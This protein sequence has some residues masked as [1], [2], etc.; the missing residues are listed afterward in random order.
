MTGAR[1]VLA[2]GFQRQGEEVR[3]TARVVEVQSGSVVRAVKMD[4]RLSAIFE[5]QDRIVAELTTGLRGTVAAAHEGE[6]TTVVAAYEALSKGLLNLR[7]DNYESLDRA[8]VF[9]ERA[10]AIDPGYV[11]AQIELASAC[12]QKGDYLAAREYHERAVAILRGV[13]ES[14]PRL[15]RVW[16][17][18]GMTLV[19]L[20][21]VD[22][23][24][25]HLRRA[26]SLAPEDPMVLAGLARGLFVGR[27]E[28]G[29]AAALFARAVERNPQ[30][31]WYLMQLAHCY[32][33]VRD[34]ERGE[35]AARRAI[36]L[37]EAFIS[38]QQGVQLVGAYMRLGHLLSLQKRFR[39]A[40]DA[41]ASE[42]AFIERV[43]HAL[44]SRIRVE[45]H[46]R[47]GGAWLAA[48]DRERADTDFAAGLGA[49][50]SRVA[51]GADEPFTRYYAA[52]I[53]A[54]R[55]ERDDAVALL[56]SAAAER[57]AFTT[58]RARI[59][60]EWDGLRDD[61]RFK[62]FLEPA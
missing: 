37:Q 57:P 23:G 5:L 47:L 2:G 31:G 29:E 53:H 58:A 39:E 54:L 46:M 40:G 1:W 32:A 51:L 52:A 19:S 3:V 25:E 55:N 44:R 6:E 26:Q 34:F 33:L 45:L 14:R 21:R 60:P 7:A 20:G 49:F 10:T 17:E 35:R 38:G 28:F 42:L 11:R 9:F 56:E 30:A 59:E 13:L 8:I 22:D 24:I 50:A 36:E 12:A 62:R 16:R 27:A 43:D 18:L 41:F 48:G 61:R 15:P 4:G